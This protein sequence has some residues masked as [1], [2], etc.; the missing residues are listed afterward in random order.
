M[1]KIAPSILTA[2]FAFM[3][4]T[5]KELEKSGA[6]YIHLD[7][8]DGHFVPNITFGSAF[9]KGIRGATNLPL[10]VHLM[11]DNPTDY[12]DDFASSGA[13]IITVHTECR[14][15]LHLNRLLVQIKNSGKKAGVALNPATNPNVLEYIYEYLDLILVMSVNP[16]FGGQ[17]FIPEALRKIEY[18][19]NRAAQIGYKI[20]IEVDGGINLQ[21]A[22][23]VID[24][25]ANV[26]VAGN[27]VISSNNMKETI[28]AL[29]EGGL[30]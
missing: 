1:I 25:G 27:A 9:V 8:M 22:K 13:D 24:A 17:K 6:D 3:G 14:S 12:I 7:V 10:D 19:A 18:V 28:T 16:G 29:R 11:I 21:T 30:L 26:L 4:D 20:E 5:I 2:D 15:A 23:S